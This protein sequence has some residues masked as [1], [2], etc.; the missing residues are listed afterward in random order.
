MEA[1]QTPKQLVT[2][3]LSEQLKA[4][5]DIN[6][7]SPNELYTQFSE[8]NHNTLR[9]YLSKFKK[10]NTTQTGD[11]GNTTTPTTNTTIGHTTTQIVHT[12]MGSGLDTGTLDLLRMLIENRA[13]LKA[14]LERERVRE[15]KLQIEGVNMDVDSFIKTGKEFNKDY[16][17]N[18]SI[19]LHKAFE[20]ECKAVGLSLRKGLHLA[21]KLFIDAGKKVVTSTLEQ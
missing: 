10:Q 17:Y 21:L 16:N 8:L 19:E 2:A 1:E 4:G 18:L 7:I 13:L 14:V 9:D 15:A 6:A 3:Y 5:R 11:T 20:A 12:T